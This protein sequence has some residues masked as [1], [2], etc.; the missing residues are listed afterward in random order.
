MT[1]VDCEYCSTVFGI[2]SALRANN[3]NNKLILK[4]ILLAMKLYI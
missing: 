4:H 2:I 3:N 1:V